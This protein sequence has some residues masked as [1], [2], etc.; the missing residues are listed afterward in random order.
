MKR[1]VTWNEVEDYVR[2]VCDKFS[3][4]NDIVLDPFFGTGTTGAMAK[5]LGRNYIGIEREHE[6]VACLNHAL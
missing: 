6:Y 5:L 2:R 3:D 1:Y 4:K